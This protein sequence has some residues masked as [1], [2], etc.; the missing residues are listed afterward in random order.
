MRT[1]KSES[2]I[3]SWC[4]TYFPVDDARDT[5]WFIDLSR[6]AGI[7]YFIVGKEVCPKSKNLHYQGFI[8]FK[9]GKTFK[10]TK[11]W[12]G[13]DRIHLEAAAGN[14]LQNERYCGKDGN[15]LV[16]IGK[17][18]AQGKRTDIAQAI[19]I[20]NETSSMREVLGQVQNYQAAR[21]GELYLK[22]LEKKRPRGKINVIWIYGS[23]GTGKTLKVFDENSDG[24]D[25]FRPV[26]Y[27]WWE[28]YDAHKNVLIDDYRIDYCSFRELITL[29]DI[30]PF[31]VETKGGS[32]QIQFQTIY[33]TA[34][35]S[36]EEMWRGHTDEDLYQLTR[37]ITQTI[38]MDELR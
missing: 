3:R 37:R 7:R 28:G 17:P 18:L 21:H 9:N 4:F 19:D 38:N 25:I 23:S 26:N 36:P 30:Y 5:V 10:S 11:K 2:K 16:E 27:K 20:L 15:L 22:Y 31:R 1:K 13:L 33:I 35:K 32:R 14:D 24:D 29:I 8:S 6:R 34:P 12:F